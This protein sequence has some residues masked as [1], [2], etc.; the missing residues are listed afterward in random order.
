MR[1]VF[2][3][4]RR[5]CRSRLGTSDRDSQVP[6]RSL[7]VRLMS[8]RRSATRNG[9]AARRTSSC[10][11]DCVKISLKPSGGTP[12]DPFSQDERLDAFLSYIEEHW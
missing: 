8:R 5:P 2:G 6:A 12:L 4:R 7:T 10:S 3:S 11:L 9:A 1:S